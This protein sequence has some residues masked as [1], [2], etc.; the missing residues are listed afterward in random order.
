MVVHRHGVGVDRGYPVSWARIALKKE[1][2]GHL[3]VKTGHILVQDGLYAVIL[4]P[5]NNV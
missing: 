1:Y 4:H 5:A 2:S 3:E